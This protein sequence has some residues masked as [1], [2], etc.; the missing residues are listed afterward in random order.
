MRELFKT[1]LRYF[2]EYG[3][4]SVYIFKFVSNFIDTLAIAVSRYGAS[5]IEAFGYLREI[6][7]RSICCNYRIDLQ[8]RWYEQRSERDEDERGSVKLKKRKN[9]TVRVVC[10]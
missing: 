5:E 2:K 4:L 3:G 9:E 6:G 8:D 10:R 7:G 1:K